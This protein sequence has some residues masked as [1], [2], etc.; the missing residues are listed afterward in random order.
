MPQP[1][2]L[3]AEDEDLLRTILT[4]LLQGAGYRVAAESNAEAAL[5]RFAADGWYGCDTPSSTILK[6]VTN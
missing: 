5:E 6:T 4:Q 3:I 1:L 2:I